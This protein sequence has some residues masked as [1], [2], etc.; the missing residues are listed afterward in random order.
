MSEKEK[1]KQKLQF[2]SFE[3]FFLLKQTTLNFIRFPTYVSVR[4]GK[5]N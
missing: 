3:L 5:G 1:Q 4:G 2:Q